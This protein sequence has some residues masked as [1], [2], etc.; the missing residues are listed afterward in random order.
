MLVRVNGPCIDLRMRV[1]ILSATVHC[2]WELPVLGRVECNKNDRMEELK[3]KT[4]I[5]NVHI[6]HSEETNE[7]M[8]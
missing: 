1:Q 7:L 3:G 2:T 8:I 6:R 4:K 5:C